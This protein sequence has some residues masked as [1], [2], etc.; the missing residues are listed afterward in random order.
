MA[1]L[2]Q[3]AARLARHLRAGA[4]TFGRSG[5]VVPMGVLFA[6][7]VAV[8]TA[9]MVD[10]QRREAF[11]REQGNAVLLAR[12]LEDH[13]TRTFNSA[14]VLLKVAA[15]AVDA[16]ATPD[17]A[18]S[19]L[20]GWMSEA[21]RREPFLRSVS[22]LDA[23]GTV[24]A[25]SNL[26]LMSLVL[27]I[28]RAFGSLPQPG[29]FRI[30]APIRGRDLPASG[31]SGDLREGVFTIPLVRAV[32][33]R[34]GTRLYLVAT[35]NPDYFA[36]YYELAL[37]EPQ[38][39]VV[40]SSYDGTLLA[41]T[42][43][44]DIAPGARLAD[45]VVFREFLP[46]RE[47]ASYRDSGIGPGDSV[48]AFRTSK[49]MPLVVMVHMSRIKA[50]AS[51]IADSRNVVLFGLLLEGFIA[52]FTML[53]FRSAVARRA[54]QRDLADQLSFNRELIEAIPIPVY[55]KDSR[56]LYLGVNRAWEEFTGMPRGD[57]LGRDQTML[58]SREDA[59][60]HIAL[61]NE[62]MRTGQHLRYDMQVR[63]ADGSLREVMY[64]KS[65]FRRG[66]GSVGGVVGSFVDVTELKEA[67]RQIRRARDAAEDASQSK[68]EFLANMSHEIRTP[69]NGI[70]GM[71]RLALE[72]TLT[73]EQRD[74]LDVVNSSGRAL[75]RI[76]D[77]ILDFSKIEAG[78]LELE[79]IEFALVDEVGS[80]AR[81]LA[82]QAHQKGLELLVRIDPAAPARVRGDS[83]RVRQVLIN[84]MGNAVKF[85]ASGEV[86][87]VVDLMA[88]PG[89]TAAVR[90][91]V[92]DTGLGVPQDKQQLIFSAFSQADST[93]T[94]RFGGTGLGL[95]I[96]ARLVE[97]MGG[98]LVLSSEPGSGTT[99]GFTLRMPS[100]PG[101]MQ[102]V[103]R[104]IGHRVLVVEANPT[105]LALARRLFAA[106]GAR[107]DGTGDPARARELA[108]GPD[109]RHD[110][111]LLSCAL[112]QDGGIAP[113]VQQA[114]DLAHALPQAQF[115]LLLPTTG[116]GSDAR[117][118]TAGIN[119]TA[120]VILRKPLLPEDVRK[121]LEGARRAGEDAA[122]A[123]AP[124]VTPQ[125]GA[126]LAG[127]S[128]LLV[129][130]HPVNQRLMKIILEKQRLIVKTAENGQEAL[131]AL[132]A[133][134]FDLVLM[135]VQMPVM[136]GIEATERLRLR[137]QGKGGH[138]PVI[139]LTAHAMDGD[140]DRCLAA[141]MDDY[142]S[143]P[144]DPEKLK[145]MLAAWMPRAD[146]A[147]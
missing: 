127:G 5:L 34:N 51:W 61:Y 7:T 128:V 114:A 68:S 139:A 71:T 102:P 135:D 146:A 133:G 1:Q 67:E 143:K 87:L 23:Q 16:S 80:V 59:E 130:D 40:L 18:F 9:L 64:Q 42:G 36:N 91:L 147:Q 123:P 78:K 111:V 140:R 60:L 82:L 70:L 17:R 76:I 2:M 84:L 54:A 56:G 47:F 79:D 115:A 24:V 94:R 106:Q 29:A 15:D 26:E 37:D 99:F 53:A 124:A 41:S 21:V 14:D 129:E 116:E 6:L 38:D 142:L 109:G 122:P 95:A 28:Q 39:A 62:A 63:R 32:Q 65:A 22:V 93:T 113:I 52:G 69:M 105:A 85:T 4:G 120:P 101:A 55:Y 119:G 138:I 27:D 43:N 92:R 104:R 25:S 89:G 144:V 131:D 20:A 19:A 145:A 31:A 49:T 137:E 81:L 77:D 98:Q 46:E 118:W 88:S 57:V 30:A 75:L 141:G 35:I 44:V 100:P 3:R 13:A 90:F 103:S 58:D 97:M 107:V 11:D 72:T 132:E 110:V 50:V 48:A 74:Y 10:Y 8:F 136:G 108:A 125:P 83:T 126:T 66:D 112:C 12:L 86:E 33:L 96:S 45:N 134:S 121:L 73:G 117:A